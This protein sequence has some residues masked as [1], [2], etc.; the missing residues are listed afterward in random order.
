VA[1]SVCVVH[2][3]IV[4]GRV[5]IGNVSWVPSSESESESQAEVERRGGWA[6]VSS[7]DAPVTLVL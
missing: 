6:S 5:V 1:V 4:A 2:D 3:R 7:R